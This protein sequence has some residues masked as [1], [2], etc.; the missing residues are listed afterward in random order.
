M[1]SRERERGRGASKPYLRRLLAQLAW[2]PLCPLAWWSRRD[3]TLWVFGAWHGAQ[4]A[5]NARY[6]YRHV[7]DHEP[8]LRAVWL[9]HDPDVVSRV[10][11]EG[12]EAELAYSLAGTR[13]ALRAGRALVT[14][15]AEDVN[16]HAIVGAELVSLTH[17]TPL[18]HMGHDARSARLGPF[19]RL[20]D[21]QVKRWLPGKRSPDRM[22]VASEVA[23]TRMMSAYAL[24]ECRV[25][26][27]GYP[28]WQAFEE[29]AVG[30]LCR[31]GIE[32]DEYAG[33]LLYAPTLRLQ[34]QGELD[35]AQGEQLEALLPWLE[36]ERLLLLVR[37]HVSLKMQGLTALLGRSPYLHDLPVSRFPDVNALLPA[38]DGLITDYSSVMYDFA[39]L[40]RPIVLMA[41]DLEAY[42]THDVGL[43]GD[44][45]GDAPG[46]V[47]TSWSELPDAWRAVKTGQHTRQLADFVA[48]HAAL[49][50]GQECH[51]II[52][53]L[54]KRGD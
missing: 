29:D 19:T 53:Y 39:C 7:R 45:R 33:L 51:R 20:F 16:A 10:Q 44:Y 27:L 21:R 48:R 52:D 3:P 28:R 32:P 47:I 1:T 54:W 8:G 17:G 30:S 11:G 24:P 15:S 46:P 26:A 13:L 14:H 42:Q 36:R 2:L 35:L 40:S 31:G 38:M 22:L 41:P 6:L 37:G 5:D 25:A 4:Y 23:K 49:H 43:Y 50:D 12:G 9:A 18:K 34:G